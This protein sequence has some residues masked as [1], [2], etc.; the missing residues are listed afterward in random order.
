M[1]SIEQFIACTNDQKSN[2]KN[3]Q[4]NRIN[5]VTWVLNQDQIFI[6]HGYTREQYDIELSM[7]LRGA[8]DDDAPVPAKKAPKRKLAPKR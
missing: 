6:S 4:D 3:Y 7:R 2:T 8:S 5:Y 1:K